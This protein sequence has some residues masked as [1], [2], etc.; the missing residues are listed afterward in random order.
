VLDPPVAVVAMMVRAALGGEGEG[1][2]GGWDGDA[3]QQA[4]SE[5]GC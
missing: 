2:E 5:G 3:E 4:T 1:S